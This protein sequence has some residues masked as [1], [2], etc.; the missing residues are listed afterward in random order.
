VGTPDPGEIGR[1]A[2][3]ARR[4]RRELDELRAEIAARSVIE[5]ATGILM[6]R[7]GC[8]AD[9]AAQQLAHLAAEA[10]TGLVG[11]A[12][13]IAAA[14]ARDAGLAAAPAQARRRAVLV[15]AAMAAAPD[16][17]GLAESLLAEALSAEG[18]EAVAVWLLAPDGGIELAG[19]AGF[20]AREASRW[21]RIPPDMPSLPL[22]AV[23]Q[24]AEVW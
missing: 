10:G 23:R 5:R 13:D 18:A 6:E 14:S 2:A 16:A 24:D 8:P 9:E 3:L 21:R 11:I 12:A 1:L 4:Q 7:L 20:G 22:R 19:E 17:A 15:G